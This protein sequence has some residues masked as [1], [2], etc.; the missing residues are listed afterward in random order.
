MDILFVFIPSSVLFGGLWDSIIIVVEMDSRWTGQRYYAEGLIPVKNWSLVNKT[1][2]RDLKYLIMIRCTQ[3][4]PWFT[5]IIMWVTSIIINGTPLC[6]IWY[7]RCLKCTKYVDCVVGYKIY[8][9]INFFC[10]DWLSNLWKISLAVLCSL[11]WF[12]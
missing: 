9:V 5:S 8:V 7:Y 6:Q 3:F 4:G 1:E 12:M 11:Y 2:E 10:S